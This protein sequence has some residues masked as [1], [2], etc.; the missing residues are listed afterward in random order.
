MPDDLP[1]ERDRAKSRNVGT[2]PHQGSLVRA[3]D[4]QILDWSTGYLGHHRPEVLA[5]SQ[6]S[7]ESHLAL[8]HPLL[9][10]GQEASGREFRVIAQQSFEARHLG[11]A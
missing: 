6:G 1:S 7:T 4:G 5:V 10:L 3:Q 8:L 11:T 9:E 2:V